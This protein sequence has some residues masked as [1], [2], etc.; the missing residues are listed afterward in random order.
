M[1]TIEEEIKEQLMEAAEGVSLPEDGWIA[2]SIPEATE[3]VAAYVRQKL[4]DLAGEITKEGVAIIGVGKSGWGVI[5][6]PKMVDAALERVKKG[7]LP[8]P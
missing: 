5:E 7:E 4:E 6:F 3:Y 1:S 8:K 2:I